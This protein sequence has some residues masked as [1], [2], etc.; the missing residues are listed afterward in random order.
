MKLKFSLLSFRKTNTEA[1]Q[2]NFSVYAL[3]GKPVDHSGAI[4]VHAFCLE[5][6]FFHSTV[7]STIVPRGT[8]PQ[9]V[10]GKP[11][12]PKAQKDALP[13]VT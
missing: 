11:A 2:R 6:L 9:I 12:N 13:N 5:W 4:S 7:Y 10:V 3:K 8:F 1:I